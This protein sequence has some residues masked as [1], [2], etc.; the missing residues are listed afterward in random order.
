MRRRRILRRGKTTCDAGTGQS[1][2][3]GA[4]R[5]PKSAPRRGAPPAG[6]T[7]SIV[8][9][10]LLRREVMPSP[11]EEID[12]LLAKSVLNQS[13][14]GFHGDFRAGAQ[15]VRSHASAHGLIRTY[16]SNWGRSSTHRRLV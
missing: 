16:C 4:A 6:P 9:A 11:D 14:E 1:R 13:F 2:R 15:N 12:Q 10:A 5:D 3:N 7:S 8:V